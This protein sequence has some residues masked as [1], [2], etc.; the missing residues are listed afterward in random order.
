MKKIISC[1]FIT[2]L[3]FSTSCSFFRASSNHN[4]TTYQYGIL[5]GYFEASLNQVHIVCERAVKNLELMKVTSTKDALVSTYEV[6]NAK[7]ETI[8]ITFERLG[9]KLTKVKIK[10]GLIGDSA[11]SQEIYDQIKKL[12]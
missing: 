4:G 2:A 10:V 8:N 6:K 3:I 9:D 7:G 11:Y 12:L 1:L 5:E